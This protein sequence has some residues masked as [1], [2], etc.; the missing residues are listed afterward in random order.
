[1]RVRSTRKLGPRASPL[2]RSLAAPLLKPGRTGGGHA[3]GAAPGRSAEEAEASLP[4]GSRTWGAEPRLGPC[5]PTNLPSRRGR[6]QPTLPTPD[7][8]RAVSGRT[9]TGTVAQGPGPARRTGLAGGAHATP[10][11]RGPRRPRASLLLR[12]LPRRRARL[13]RRPRAAQQARPCANKAPR[14][15]GERR[16]R[17]R[18]ERLRP[19]RASQSPRL[20]HPPAPRPRP[21]PRRGRA[22]PPLCSGARR[23]RARPCPS[24]PARR[25]RRLLRAGPAGRGAGGLRSPGP[26]PRPGLPSSPP[27][28]GL[29]PPAWTPRLRGAMFT[30][31]HHRNTRAP[32]KAGAEVPPPHLRGLL[33]ERR[34]GP[35]RRVAAAPPGKFASCGAAEPLTRRAE[36]GGRPPASHRPPPPSGFIV[37]PPPA[38][39]WGSARA[40]SRRAAHTPTPTFPPSCAPRLSLIRAYSYGP[41]QAPE[42]TRT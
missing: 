1:M 17:P 4:P 14:A 31:F 27:R 39:G 20:G 29:L 21:H 25:P 13:P 7:T 8:H 18:P 40:P 36:R 28:P 37:W 33:A 6:P 2:G 15:G 10:R 22:S 41:T 3:G 35:G 42:S 5:G 26:A 11:L 12:G 19:G 34:A 32:G 16:S 30:S 38:A 23:R 9:P 24:A